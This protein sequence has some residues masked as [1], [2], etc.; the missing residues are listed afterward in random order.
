[1]KI[2]FRLKLKLKFRIYNGYV[3]FV[4]TQKIYS[5]IVEKNIYMS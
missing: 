5:V 4:V 2:N 1:M 3:K